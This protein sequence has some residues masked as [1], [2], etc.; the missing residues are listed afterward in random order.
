MIFNILIG[1]AAFFGGWTLNRIY[2]AIDRLDTDVRDIP[3]QY[4]SKTDYKSDMK[5]VKEMLIRILDK[6]DK[7][8]DK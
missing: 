6:L 5:D 1:L 8:A 3:T 7:K 2:Q 4:V